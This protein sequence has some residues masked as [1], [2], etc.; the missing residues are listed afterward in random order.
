M[1]IHPCIQEQSM[2][3][4]NIEQSIICP[5]KTQWRGSLLWRSG[6]LNEAEQEYG[7]PNCNRQGGGLN[8]MRE[9]GRL[10]T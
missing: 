9:C 7:S 4:I 6:V 3:H 1:V 8:M 2:G 10:P 5:V